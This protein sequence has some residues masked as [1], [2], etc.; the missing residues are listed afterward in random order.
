[1]PG[2]QA[3][4]VPVPVP[5]VVVGAALVRHGRV[6]AARRTRPAALR[7]R[8]ELPGG[9]VE[10][11]EEPAAAV[12][13]E[14][15]EELGCE[16]RVTG[17]LS[18]EQPVDGGRTLQVWCAEIVSGEPVPH[19]HD[20]VRWLAPEQLD[21]VGWLAP[22]LPFLDDLRE[23]LLDG[24]RL[25]GGNVGGAVRIGGTVRR[26]TGPWTPAVHRLLDHVRAAGLR[27][28]PHVLGAD[29]RGR[30][31]LSYLPGTV[32]DVD[33]EVLTDAQLRDVTRW[34]RELHEAVAVR[35]HDGPWRF[36]G[37][38]EPTVLAHN[39]LAPYN[40]CFEGDRL[41]GV[42]DWDLAG[43]STPLL[44]LALLAWTGIPLVRPVAARDAA[45][46]LEVMATAYGGLTGQQILAAVPQRVRLA[47]DGIRTAVADGDEQMRNLMLIGEPERSE[48]ALADL[49]TRMHDIEREL[50]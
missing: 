43:P 28:V 3:L 30:E 29:E 37:V 23:V 19:E 27:A 24:H 41:T 21:E 25:P 9:K 1:M 35:Q 44:E 48:R 11:G 42:F 26:P 22:D 33:T 47:V 38:D 20:A 32:V 49:M 6:L 45:R 50:T 4:P 31:V 8:W 40:T 2:V 12:V 16:V 39:D 10:P 5:V 46:R 36:F 7:G 18:G 34:A 13:R 17:R 14:V 15:R